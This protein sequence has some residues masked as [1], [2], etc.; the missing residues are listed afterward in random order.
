MKDRDS[1]PPYFY[2]YY[3]MGLMAMMLLLRPTLC[4]LLCINFTPVS[5]FLP[6]SNGISPKSH[7]NFWIHQTPFPSFLCSEQNSQESSA[8]PWE[9]ELPT[10]DGA[11]ETLLR[12]HLSVKSSDD[13]V[14][15]TVEKALERVQDYTQSF[16]FAAVL[17]VQPLQYLPTIDGGVDLLFLRKKTKEK[18]S[19]DG[20]LRFF[21]RAMEGNGNGSGIDVLVKRNSK[22]QSISKSFTEKL[23]VQ[24][25]VQGIS[26]ESDGKTGKAP[27]DL[28]SVESV[29]HKWL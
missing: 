17:P 14:A 20:G 15:T 4:L 9:D 5:C 18:G 23:V 28:V 10:D 8:F 26:G 24:A 2:H 25:Y 3:S 6:T 16:P 22:G 12:I 21:V 27:T 11:E 1:L 13:G 29:F 7:G 19:V